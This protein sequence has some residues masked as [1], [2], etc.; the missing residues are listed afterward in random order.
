MMLTTILAAAALADMCAK[1]LTPLKDIER[2]DGEIVWVEGGKA[3]FPIVADQRNPLVARAAKFLQTSVK[4]MT[5]VDVKIVR[6]HAKGPAVRIA[7]PDPL[8]SSIA[9]EIGPDGVALAGNGPFAAYDFAER[10]LGVRQYFDEKEGGRSVIKTDRIAL[11]YVKWTDKPMY[12]FREMHPN[13]LP[14]TY[15]YKRAAGGYGHSVHTPR[16]ISEKAG[17][18]KD[19]EPYIKTRPEIFELSANGKRGM[20]NMLCYGNPKTLETYVERIEQEIAGIRPAGRFVNKT[21]KIITVS[22]DDAS[23][24]CKCEYCQKIIDPSLGPNGLYAP[25]LWRHFVPKLSDIVAKRWPDWTI[26]ILPYHNTCKCLPDVHFTNGNVV[27]WLVTHPGLAMLKDRRVKNEEEAKMR[28]WYRCTG[29][30][31]VNWHYL[32]YPASYTPAPYLFGDAIVSHYRDVSDIVA[33]SYVDQYSMKRKGHELDLYVWFRALWN[34]WFEPSDVYDVF[35]ERMFGPAAKE[36]REIVRLTADGWKRDWE[37]PIV[38]LK[39]VFGVSYPV[40]ETRR[41]KA[42]AE[43]AKAKL[44]GDALGLKRFEFFMLHYWSFFADS[45]EY[46][47]GGAFTPLEVMKTADTPKVDGV[48]DDA[49]WKAAKP[50][51]F[52]EAINTERVLKA[53]PDATEMMSVWTPGYGVTFGFRCHEAHMD[54]VVRTKPPCVGNDQVEFF[55][56]PSGAGNG[57]Y[58]QIA[59]DVNGSAMFYKSRRGSI[60]GWKGEGIVAAA[61]SYADRWE[62]EVYV[63]FDALREFPGAR[64]PN[65]GAVNLKWIGNATRMQYGEGKDPRG[66]FSRLF[67]K[68]NWWNNHTAAFGTL[69]FK[70]W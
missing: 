29:R 36:M 16:W 12:T 15:H 34:P 4:E 44:A 42:L 64:I 63:P 19:G 26:S 33:G 65:Q 54:K 8:D 55:L 47:S 60:P 70:E 24:A 7:V 5:G 35:C 61:K 25:I 37:E 69:Q 39:A 52:V 66:Y 68:F 9:V 18:E 27:A 53:P 14:W 51:S 23:L 21:G 3:A 1:D 17:V 32:I 13:Q 2:R 10:V 58:L 28:E 43:A 62:L 46:A 38:S 49:A 45:E 40:E 48:L 6:Q 30:K 57:G 50:S 11:P 31:I 56:D 41:M 67:T 22:Q 59:V 20:S